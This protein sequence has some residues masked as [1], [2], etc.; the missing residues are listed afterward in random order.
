MTNKSYQKQ[1][2]K[3]KSKEIKKDWFMRWKQRYKCKCCWH[4][5]Q[6]KTRANNIEIKEI[7]NDYCFWKQTYSQL[8]E[9][10]QKP[11]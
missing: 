5:F 1:C 4:V 6:N 9:I 10:I 11:E 3:C 2:K 7:W 8:S